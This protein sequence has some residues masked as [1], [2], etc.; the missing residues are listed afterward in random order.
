MALLELL[1]RAWRVVSAILGRP[2]RE[3]SEWAERE[4]AA[5]ANELELV[6]ALLEGR[7]RAYRDPDGWR[8]RRDREI[9]RSLRT[10]ARQLRAAVLP[11]DVTRACSTRPGTLPIA[12]APAVGSKP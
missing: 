3:W 4:P 9:A 12:S 6:A 11:E 7:S 10:H 8:G 1:S 2:F 5:A